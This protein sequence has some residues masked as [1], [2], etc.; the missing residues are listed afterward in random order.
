[1]PWQVQIINE[2]L[3]KV[4]CR[5]KERYFQE[6]DLIEL[7]DGSDAFGKAVSGELLCCEPDG[8]MC[9]GSQRKV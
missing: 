1:M 6:P 2:E 3:E 9:L 8:R 5:K 7:L 4:V